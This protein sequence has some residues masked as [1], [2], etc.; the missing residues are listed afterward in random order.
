MRRLTQTVQNNVKAISVAALSGKASSANANDIN[1][2]F[3]V[4][5]NIG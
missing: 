5:L 1:D 2:I 4:L 3:D